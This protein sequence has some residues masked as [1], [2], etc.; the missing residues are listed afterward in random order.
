MKCK[1][2]K[3]HLWIISVGY[4]MLIAGVYLRTTWPEFLMWGGLFTVILGTI[5]WM[6]N[7]QGF[8]VS[9]SD[10]DRHEY[11]LQMKFKKI[12]PYLWIVSVGYF[13]L[14]AGIS[15]GS[16][17]YVFLQLC[18]IFTMVQGAI[19][20]LGNAPGAFGSDEDGNEYNPQMKFKK[21]NPHFW[22]ILVGYLMFMAGIYLQS[23]WSEF[24]LQAGVYTILLG[25]IVLGTEKYMRDFRSSL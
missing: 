16:D 9:G 23:D 14:M 20:R 15:L 8:S 5:G 2:I 7:S 6:G 25:V 13:A 3:P 19:G 1:K 10:E 22:I 4:L 17:W 21:I 24:L 18:G 12:N 11:N